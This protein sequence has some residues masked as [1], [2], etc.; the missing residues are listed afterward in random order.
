MKLNHD[1][2]LNPKPN[3]DAAAPD[4]SIE[5]IWSKCNHYYAK[6]ISPHCT[7]LLEEEDDD[8]IGVRIDLVK[9]LQHKAEERYKIERQLLQDERCGQR[10]LPF[11]KEFVDDYVQH[12]SGGK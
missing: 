7:L 8:I 5:V 2:V 6:W 3:Y 12:L 11:D 1:L 10:W 4:G 9:I